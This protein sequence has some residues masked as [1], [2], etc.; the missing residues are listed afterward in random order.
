MLGADLAL[1]LQAS[2][3]VRHAPNGVADA[4]CETRLINPSPR[5]YGDLDVN[6][7]TDKVIERLAPIYQS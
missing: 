7:D 3:L 2:L 6:I 4:F 1:A 5:V